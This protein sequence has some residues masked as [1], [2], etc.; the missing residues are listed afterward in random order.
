MQTLNKRDDWTRANFYDPNPLNIENAVPARPGSAGDAGPRG[1]HGRGWQRG[2]VAGRRSAARPVQHGDRVRRPELGRRSRGAVGRSG[3]THLPPGADAA[4]GTLSRRS[5]R[6]IGEREPAAAHGRDS[7]GASRR[8]DSPAV[9]GVPAPLVRSD[10]RGPGHRRWRSERDLLTRADSRRVRA[11]AG[12]FE[13]GGHHVAASRTAR[14]RADD[15]SD[16]CAGRSGRLR[17]VAGLQPVVRLAGMHSENAGCRHL[18]AAG[19]LDDGLRV[20]PGLC[21]AS[22]RADFDG[23]DL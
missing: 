4:A 9:R 5:G 21:L 7:S 18:D 11:A 3:R 16:R 15:L 12:S 17:R 1:M 6:I 19:R 2:P 8:A 20:L 10:H 13:S 14:R 23:A 22:R